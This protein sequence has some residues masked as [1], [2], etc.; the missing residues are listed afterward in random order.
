MVLPSRRFSFFWISACDHTKPTDN[1][2]QTEAKKP[3]TKAK[4]TETEENKPETN[5]KQTGNESK[6]TR[7]VSIFEAIFYGVP[8]AH[9][10]FVAGGLS[11]PPEF[12]FTKNK[13]LVPTAFDQ[14]KFVQRFC[15]SH[16]MSELFAI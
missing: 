6:Q 9:D 10:V 16:F 15:G 1:R 14:P 8:L 4:K 12:I 3:D 7:S 13:I 5:R 11:G 2:H